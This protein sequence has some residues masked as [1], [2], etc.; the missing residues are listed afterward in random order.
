MPLIL[1]HK[2]ANAAE[3]HHFFAVGDD[4]RYRM[5]KS[6]FNFGANGR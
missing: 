3:Q 1:Q 4:G 6:T 5:M 2:Q